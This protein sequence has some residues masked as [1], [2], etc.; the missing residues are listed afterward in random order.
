MTATLRS[1]KICVHDIMLWN[2]MSRFET[3][4]RKK[5]SSFYRVMYV[6]N[7]SCRLCTLDNR[8]GFEQAFMIPKGSFCYIPPGVWYYTETPDGLENINIMFYYSSDNTTY[9]NQDSGTIDL[10]IGESRT[11]PL[12]TRYS[13]SDAAML[14]DVFS[15]NDTFCGNV[16]VQQICEEWNTRYRYSTEMLDSLTAQL[17]YNL[18]R[19]KEFQNSFGSR[20]VADKTITYISE[21]FREKIDCQSV[22][23]ALGYHPNYLHTVIRDTTGVGLHRYIM[24][25]KLRHAVY[26]IDHTDMKISDI[27][28]SLSFNDASHFTNAYTAK[29]GISPSAQRKRNMAEKTGENNIP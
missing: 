12:C 15:V 22:A 14:S 5:V 16:L 10:Q 19:Q 27:A 4:S 28:A 1:V 23:K 18:V 2:N 6:Q 3:V 29:M 13:F 21:H 9:E 26:L 20:E 25:T 17:V 8:G 24:D 7:G 11:P